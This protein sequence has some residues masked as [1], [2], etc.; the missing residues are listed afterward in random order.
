MQTTNLQTNVNAFIFLNYYFLNRS[1]YGLYA[2][3]VIK[4]MHILGIKIINNYSFD[5]RLPS[6]SK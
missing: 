1:Y 5:R 4:T 6:V 3:T 2:S